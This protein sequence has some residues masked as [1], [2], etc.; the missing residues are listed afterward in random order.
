M[1]K[2]K[3]KYVYSYKKKDG[4]YY[5]FSYEGKVKRGY[6]SASTCYQALQKIMKIDFKEMN[7]ITFPKLVSLYKKWRFSHGA[8]STHEKI[9]GQ[10]VNYMLPYFDKNKT[11]VNY[12]DN[13]FRK[14]YS[15]L[16]FCDLEKKNRVLNR[17]IDI[18]K[19]F[20]NAYGYHCIYVY[21][22]PK[23]DSE[24]NIDFTNLN[25]D[26]FY[27]QD[28]IMKIYKS[29]KEEE[30]YLLFKKICVI[31]SIC[32]CTR[33]SELRGLTWDHY[34][35]KR[36]FIDSQLYRGKKK[37]LKSKRSYRTFNLLSFVNSLFIKWKETTRYNDPEDY[38]FVHPG[39]KK[40][41]SPQSIRRYIEEAALSVGLVYRNPH[42]GRHT[43]ATLIR[44]VGGDEYVMGQIL[45]HSPDVA[46]KIYA[47]AFQEEKNKTIESI[48]ELF[49]DSSLKT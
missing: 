3:Y 41:V 19:Y 43:V 17:L 15:N 34:D 4:T 45:G 23:F 18:F 40:V 8:E 11:I 16:K 1:A 6:K 24:E 46:K 25:D 31:S 14:F 9:N 13:D 44:Q 27:N 38:I 22:L 48:D 5:Y 35:G 29:M 32:S 21:R 47:H 26:N 7:D 28:E 20:E 30:P 33:I 36:L 37:K 42:K 49:K 10:I 12:N 2:T 39:T